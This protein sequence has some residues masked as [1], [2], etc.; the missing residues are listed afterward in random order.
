MLHVEHLALADYLDNLTQRSQVP[1]EH[2]VVR[3]ARDQELAVPAEVQAVDRLCMARKSALD[4]V[5]AEVPEDHLLVLRG[6]RQQLVVEEELQRPD[7]QTVALH[8]VDHL[9]L[10]IQHQNVPLAA[11]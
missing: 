8:P 1:H 3:G 9:E 2:A 11:H 10:R 4:A 5:V 7:R 6:R